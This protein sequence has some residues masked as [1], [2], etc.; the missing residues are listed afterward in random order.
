MG[1]L[2]S[3]EAITSFSFLSCN[4]ENGVNEFSTFGVVTLGPVVS[5]S[6]LTE[7][8][9]V[10]SEELTEWSSSN[11]VHCS[12]FKIHKDGTGDISS[13]SGFVVIDVDSFKLKIRVSVIGTS[14]VDSV[15]IRDDLPELGTDLV[16]ALTSL[17]MDYL[18]HEI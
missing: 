17:N 6:G 11:R 15:F 13:T 10:R 18:S 16:T 4:I 3:L 8:E 14:W 5:G 2:E 12:G 1:D 7:D 9:V